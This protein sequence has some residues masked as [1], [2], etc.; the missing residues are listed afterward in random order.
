MK[1]EDIRRMLVA[2][3]ATFRPTE[4]QRRMVKMYAFNGADV[5]KIARALNLSE[6]QLLFYFADEMNHGKEEMLA[7]AAD[8]VFKLAG[9]LEDEPATA[10]KANQLIL[11]SKLRTWRV[12]K[13]DEE[14]EDR[15]PK[16]IAKMTLAETEA[17]IDRLMEQRKRATAGGSGEESANTESPDIVG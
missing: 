9:M 10:L 6:A 12:P 14:P 13:T 8:N 1:R 11:Q 7:W 17:E 5:P 16:A 4:A 15:R 2:T 3:E